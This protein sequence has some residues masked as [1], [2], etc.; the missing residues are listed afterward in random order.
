MNPSR[1]KAKKQILWG[2]ILLLIAGAL[3]WF[4]VRPPTIF[5]F[6]DCVVSGYPVMESYPRQCKMPNGVTFKEDIGNELEKDGFIR[7]AQ[8]RPNTVIESPLVVKGMA[9]GN[10]FFEASFPVKLFDGNGELLASVPAQAKGEWM[11]TEFVPF[12][13]TLSFK[14]PTTTV[15]LL[16]L[17]KDNPSGLPEHDDA[18]RVPVRFK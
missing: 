5:T 4:G 3:Y 9:R 8:P 6:S 12:E 10:W 7:I 2:V 16:L 15:G 17:Q 11:T 18:L 14:M 1:E 13:A